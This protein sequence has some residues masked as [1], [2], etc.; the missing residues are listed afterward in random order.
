RGGFRIVIGMRANNPPAAVA[1]KVRRMPKL[2]RLIAYKAL[3][4]L[5]SAAARL[6]NRGRSV[7][8]DYLAYDVSKLLRAERLAQRLRDGDEVLDV[9]CGNGHLLRDLG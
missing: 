8:R 7:P 5:Q 3:G 2:A 6:A 4:Q 1:W 9:G